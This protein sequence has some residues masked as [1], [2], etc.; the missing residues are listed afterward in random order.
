MKLSLLSG[1]SPKG[2]VAAL[3]R[4]GRRDSREGL[5]VKMNK[6]REIA[7]ELVKRGD[8]HTQNVYYMYVYT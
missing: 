1:S 6:R 3:P 4:R 5:C 7:R 2:C 8:T